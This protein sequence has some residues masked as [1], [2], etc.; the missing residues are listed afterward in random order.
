MTTE[1]EPDPDE[2][3]PPEIIKIEDCA[4]AAS[5]YE[6]LNAPEL[7]RDDAVAVARL[8]AQ[9]IS[10]S[11]GEGVLVGES[12]ADLTHVIHHLGGTHEQIRVQKLEFKR[13]VEVVFVTTAEVEDTLLGPSSKERAAAALLKQVLASADSETLL[14]LLTNVKAP[15]QLATRLEELLKLLFE[16]DA[17]LD[18]QTPNSPPIRVVP[19]RAQALYSSLRAQSA[20]APERFTRAGKLVGAFLDTRDFKLRLDDPWRRKNVIEGKF[21]PGLRPAIE[22]LFNQEV[23]AGVMVEGE[24]LG[25]R[26]PRLK[27]TLETLDAPHLPQRFPLA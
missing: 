9:R 24:H 25:I 16:N 22:Q 14:Q 5:P 8:D 13:S 4:D 15:E 2:V 11:D 21:V 7:D 1:D 27:F 18:L 26:P 19:K 23:M 17:T 3:P 12:I 10:E 20:L 6:S